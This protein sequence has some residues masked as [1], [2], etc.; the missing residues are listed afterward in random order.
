MIG[1][2]DFSICCRQCCIPRRCPR[3][4]LQVGVELVPACGHAFPVASCAPSFDDRR[5]RGR[6]FCWAQGRAQGKTPVHMV[7]RFVLPRSPPRPAHGH[8]ESFPHTRQGIKAERDAYNPA[9][10]SVALPPCDG[11]C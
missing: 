2:N 5:C 3:T 6:P 7:R 10:P 8:K 4:S 1:K 9:P 11:V